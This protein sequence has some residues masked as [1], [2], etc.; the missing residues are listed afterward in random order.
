MRGARKK[1]GIE[2]QDRKDPDPDAKPTVGFA[3]P[4]VGDKMRRYA[5]VRSLNAQI[6]DRQTV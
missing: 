3:L 1:S 2:E 6:G 5:P 4:R